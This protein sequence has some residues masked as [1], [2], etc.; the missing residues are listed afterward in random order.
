MK[1]IPGLL[2]IVFKKT[3]SWISST[4]EM[5]PTNKTGDRYEI[6]PFWCTWHKKLRGI[7]TDSM[8]TTASLD[9]RVSLWTLLPSMMAYVLG[10]SFLNE[11]VFHLLVLLLVP[12]R[13]PLRSDK[14]S[15]SMWWCSGRLHLIVEILKQKAK[16]SI[17][18]LSYNFTSVKKLVHGV[19]LS[20]TMTFVL[21]FLGPLVV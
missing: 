5:E 7:H 14:E 11:V 10:Y 12:N 4:S 8:S 13:Y 2:S 18:R 1:N 16:S 17:L 20:D 9:P 19:Q 21:A 15:I 6:A 3:D